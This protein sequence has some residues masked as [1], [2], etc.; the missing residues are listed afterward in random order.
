LRNSGPLNWRHPGFPVDGAGL[1]TWPF[2]WPFTWPFTWP[3][4]IA[5]ALSTPGDHPTLDRERL[6]LVQ[7]NPLRIFRRRAQTAARTWGNFDHRGYAAL[8][9]GSIV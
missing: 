7:R 5:A 9:L 2:A 4:L 1:V 3:S 6:T 8:H